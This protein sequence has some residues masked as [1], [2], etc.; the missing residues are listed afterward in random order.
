MGNDINKDSFY[1]HIKTMGSNMQIFYDEFKKSNYLRNIIK[2]WDIDKLQTL[3]VINLNKYFDY[4]QH[5]K[6]K[7]ED[8]E[9]N[10]REVLI[11]KLNNV[12]DPIVNILFDQMNKLS[13]TYYM[14]LVL[15]LTVNNWNQQLII[16]TENYENIDPRLI[17]VE[18]YTE[19]PK[20]LEKKIYPILLRFCSI[21]NELGDIFSVGKGKDEERFDLNETSFLFN[22]NIACIGRFG[23]GKSTCVNAIIKEYK[24]KESSKGSSQTKN[25]TFYQIK[26]HPIRI[27][28][29][30]GFENEKI[31]KDAIV[32]F[33]LCGE[34]INK[35]KDNIHIILYFLNY[36]E[37]RAFM[38][39]EYPIIEEITKHKTSK[40][41]YVITHS[42]S[43]ITGK[44]K[45]KILE[46]INSGIKGITKISE[47]IEK[48]KAN[49][50]NVVFVN[51]HKNVLNDEE[52]FGKKEL[53]KKI[54]EIFIQSEDYNNSLKNLTRENI[55]KNA[56]KLRAQAEEKLL[57][58]KIW[59]L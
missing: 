44:I 20:K 40:I 50:N 22:L 33:K 1:M 51:F 28:D 5:I 18:N 45:D 54:Y 7:D 41:I 59:E 52:P 11:L 6:D 48:F 30:P 46:R 31:V 9:Q 14:P 39:L 34:K 37:K 26:N 43:N 25:L 17:F 57:W 4:L 23:Q 24:A 29:I 56:L 10:I 47:Q 58:N 12:F 27:L 13:E 38:K 36:A 49:D 15:L 53:F 55:E 2:Y 8:K 3:N 16:D 21:H 35:L 19:N 42:K 32:K